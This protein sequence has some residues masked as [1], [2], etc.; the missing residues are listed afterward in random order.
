MDPLT[1]DLPSLSPARASWRVAPAV[2]ALSICVAA[3]PPALAQRSQAM[4]LDCRAAEPDS[5]AARKRAEEWVRDKLKAFMPSPEEALRMLRVENEAEQAKVAFYS[6]GTT[7]GKYRAGTLSREDADLTFSG[8]EQRIADFLHELEN[9]TSVLA[10]SAQVAD[11]EKIRASL[12]TTGAVGRQAG[13]LGEDGLAEAARKQMVQTLVTFSGAFV[14]ATCWDQ[15][16][17]DELPLSIHRQNEMLDTGIDVRSCAQRRFRA[18]VSPLTF[19]S[20]TIR[21][22]GEWRVRWDM[23][24]YRT[25]GGTGTAELE[26]ERDGAK[27]GYQVEWGTSDVE[28]RASGDLE[29]TRK[30]NGPGNKATYTLAGEMDIKLTKGEEMVK[31]MAKLMNQKVGGKRSFRVEPEVSDKPC[32][33]LD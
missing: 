8:D 20:C 30:D 22:V 6:I 32:K 4:R 27:G 10:A 11:L 16:F 19:A 7:R 24:G 33:A 29:L 17:D 5:P 25:T 23:S 3:P 18:F 2:L 9:E 14:E 12:T 21:G 28:Y 1:F 15:V 31:L 13:L 26:Q